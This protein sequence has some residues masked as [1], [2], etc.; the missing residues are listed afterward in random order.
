MTNPSAKVIRL[1]SYGTL[2][3]RDVQLATFGR[4]LVGRADVLVG[5]SLSMLTITDPAVVALSG[6]SEHPM[7]RRT[8]DPRDQVEGVIFEITDAELAAADAYEVDDYAR[9][10]TVSKGGVETFVYVLAADA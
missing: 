6:E 2:R 1:F 9:V 8:G 5:F 3:Q 7:L 4:E 10:S